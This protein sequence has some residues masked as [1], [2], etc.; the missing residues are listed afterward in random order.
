MKAHRAVGTSLLL[1]RRKM[2]WSLIAGVTGLACRPNPTKQS[3]R[4]V[5][6]SA[7]S[8]PYH[9]PPL[10][11]TS[12]NHRRPLDETGFWGPI[13]ELPYIPIHATLI[14]DG[15][16]VM[17]ENG[18]Y[19]RKKRD[20]GFALDPET[21]IDEPLPSAPHDIFCAGHTLDSLGRLVVF[22]GQDGEAQRGLPHTA[23]L[24][25]REGGTFTW[26]RLGF[27]R[28]ID[29]RRWYPTA[30]HLPDG[31]IV[32]LGGAIA[33]RNK[34]QK[35]R[36][37]PIPV[38]LN[39]N[40]TWDI[41][42]RAESLPSV[43]SWLY[44][45]AGLD[46][47]GHIWTFPDGGPMWSLDPARSIWSHGPLS[48]T[49]ENH[50]Y[51]TDATYV[52]VVE[53]DDT[54]YLY[55]IGGN[56]PPTNAITRVNLSLPLAERTFVH[57]GR[58]TAPRRHPMACVLPTGE[59]LIVG[60]TSGSGFNRET[61]AVLY[62]E[63]YDP[64]TGRSRRLASMDRARLYHSTLVY[65]TAGT[66]FVGGTGNPGPDERERHAEP[67]GQLFFPP[68]WYAGN[69]EALRPVITRLPPSAR[70]GERITIGT[71][72]ATPLSHVALMACQ[73]FTHSIDP[74][75]RVLL[76]PIIRRQTPSTVS[77][78]LPDNPALIPPRYYLLVLVRQDGTYSEGAPLLVEPSLR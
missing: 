13:I 10:E 57:V 19:Q 59:I 53:P 58:M 73:S 37:N 78:T 32:V 34:G 51:R 72:D 7:S 74:N 29:N 76:R 3:S 8:S 52:T 44:L 17:W 6:P 22:G 36:I 1:T 55:L 5:G 54:V 25:M 15:T 35:A 26:D 28:S 21:G 68:H 42:W 77:I 18:G 45:Q 49:I 71:E 11:D 47:N 64:H 40:D 50:S 66:V 63:V 16:I 46:G 12:Y 75:A 62:A 67:N 23:R 33:P 48:E 43:D 31:R 61:G 70:A 20:E 14:P 27:P 24:R 65:T 38:I 30:V 69:Y 9:T 2:I 41:L 56:D 39:T 60:G 4:H